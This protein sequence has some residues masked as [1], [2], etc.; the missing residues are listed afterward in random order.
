MK[1]VEYYLGLNYRTSV[2]RDD[3][4]DFIVKV[5]EL[6]GCIADGDTPNSAFENLK[7]AMRSWIESRMEAGLD[8][9]EPKSRADFSG[10]ILLRM[11]RYLHE[12]LSEQAESEGTSL[13]QYMISLLS[14]A[15]AT[16]QSQPAVALGATNM[17]GW[18]PAALASGLAGGWQTRFFPTAGSY[19]TYNCDSLLEPNALCSV[20]Q[21][22]ISRVTVSQEARKETVLGPQLVPKQ[23]V[24]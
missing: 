6:P 16:S 22:L 1:S 15:S 9:P 19:V 10:R 23:Q 13:N 2:F 4:G 17:M 18:G 21:P 5:P 11:P 20:D 8:I 3:E 24:A 14:Q 7:V 12:R